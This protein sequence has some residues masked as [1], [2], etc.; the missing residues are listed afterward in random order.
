MKRLTIPKATVEPIAYICQVALKVFFRNPAMRPG[1]NGLGISNKPVSP[2][3]HFHRILRIS[4]DR[5]MMNNSQFLDSDLIAPPSVR[6]YL[7][8]KRCNLIIRNA[9]PEQQIFYG[10]GRSII[11][12]KGMGKPR[13]S[14][15]LDS[16]ML[17]LQ[18]APGLSFRPRAC[19]C[20]K[21][22]AQRKIHLSLP[23]RP[24]YNGHL[25]QTCVSEFCGPSPRWF[26]S[27]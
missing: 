9:Q 10:I 25:G 14:C 24:I 5:T 26:Y 13:L 1:Y 17:R 27:H 21:M 3:Q 11:G 18:S 15:H 19:A 7:S 16:P 2:R 23:N 8:K 22:L 6:P 4:K 20:Q 12:Y